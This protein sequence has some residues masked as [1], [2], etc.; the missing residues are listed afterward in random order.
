MLTIYRG[1]DKIGVN[2]VGMDGKG[3]HYTGDSA[4]IDPRGDAETMKAS[5]EDVLHTVLHREALE[6]FRAKFPVAD[7]ADDFSLML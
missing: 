1:V 7:D 5:K 2:R 4:S 6:D 3:H